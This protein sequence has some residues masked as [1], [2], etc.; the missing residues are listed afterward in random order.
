MRPG[1]RSE[2]RTSGACRFRRAK[3]LRRRVWTRRLR[4]HFGIGLAALRGGGLGATSQSWSGWTPRLPNF[5]CLRAMPAAWLQR[6]VAFSCC[7]RGRP[8]ALRSR[9]PGSRAAAG[10]RACAPATLPWSGCRPTARDAHS[11]GWR[12]PNAL[13]APR[14]RVPASAARRGG[15]LCP[16]LRAGGLGA[17]LHSATAFG[18][19][20]HRLWPPPPASDPPGGGCGC[21]GCDRRTPCVLALP[22]CAA[23]PPLGRLCRPCGEHRRTT[24][25]PRPIS[26][27]SAAA[28]GQGVN[29]GTAYFRVFSRPRR[30]RAL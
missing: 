29:H 7:P 20:A 22:R 18:L 30:R 25:H 24:S 13:L 6:T 8:A 26:T 2:S 15:G 19:P 21:G 9:A 14:N 28:S 11:A 1:S 5:G 4:S 10:R 23:P 17:A 12:R 16:P 27:K 3:G